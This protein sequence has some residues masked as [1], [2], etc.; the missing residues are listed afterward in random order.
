M[1]PKTRPHYG[2]HKSNY[3][4][5]HC[6]REINSKPKHTSKA[7]PRLKKNG[8][9]STSSMHREGRRALIFTFLLAFLVACRRSKQPQDQLADDT[10]AQFSIVDF[11]RLVLK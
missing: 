4:Q 5:H 10:I 2:K 1:L 8:K 6:C 3:T 11:C 9:G 7:T